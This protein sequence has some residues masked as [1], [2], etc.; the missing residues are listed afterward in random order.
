MFNR[1]LFLLRVEKESEVMISNNKYFFC[2][3][4][5]LSE[6]LIK[7]GHRYITR[8]KGLKTNH[9]F[10]LFEKT[11]KL[12]QLLDRWQSNIKD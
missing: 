8:A 6:H 10:A 2:Y 9:E 12:K 5:N 3:D 7:N 4:R 11:D 1:L